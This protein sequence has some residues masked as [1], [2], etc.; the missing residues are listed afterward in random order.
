MRSEDCPVPEAQR[1]PSSRDPLPRCRGCGGAVR[2]VLEQLGAMFFVCDNCRRVSAY[3]V[4]DQPK[5]S[6][7]CRSQD[8][9][10]DTMEQWK[11]AMIGKGL[12]VTP[13]CR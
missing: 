8:E 2:F 12:G 13:G 6:A 4:P 1:D 5:R 10:L 3:A 7:V 11:A 9:I